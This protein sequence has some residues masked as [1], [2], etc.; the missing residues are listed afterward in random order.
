MRRISL[1]QFAIWVKVDRVQTDEIYYARLH[2]LIQIQFGFN[3][4]LEVGYLKVELK[5][6]R[7][8]SQINT[9]RG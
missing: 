1:I 4:R 6:V 2:T 5:S 3:P 7:V 9:K 8:T